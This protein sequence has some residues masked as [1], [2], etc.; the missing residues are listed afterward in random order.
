MVP[1]RLALQLLLPDLVAAEMKP[2]CSPVCEDDLELGIG[3]LDDRGAGVAGLTDAGSRP[4]LG[5]TCYPKQTILQPRT[6]QR[7]NA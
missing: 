6:Y 4:S 5:N 7:S 2:S 3:A 1:L